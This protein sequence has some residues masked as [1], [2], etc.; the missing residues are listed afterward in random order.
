MS[1]D[2]YGRLNVNL[3]S[4]LENYRGL[5]EII[6]INPTHMSDEEKNKFLKLS[7]ICPNLKVIDDL[8]M[9]S[10]TLEEYEKAEKW[11]EDTIKNINPNW[12]KLQKIAYIDN[13]IGKKVSYSP[14]FETEVFD[15]GESRNI[16]KIINKGYGVCNGIAQL[17][18][19]MLNRIGVT[20]EIVTS[21]VHAFV[22]IKDIQI[23]IEDGNYVVGDT[24]IDPTWNLA[25]HR[26]GGR[27]NDFCVSYERIRSHDIE[28]DGKD[29]KAHKLDEENMETIEL[30]EKGLREVFSSIGIA[31]P[32]GNFPI[33]ELMDMSKLLDEFDFSGEEN[34]EKQLLLLTKYYKGFASCQNSTIRVLASMIDSTKNL[35]F[36]KCII[37]RVFDRS[38]KKKEPVLYVYANFRE[39]TKRFWVADKDLHGF[40]SISEQKFEEKFKCYDED[41]KKEDGISPWKAKNIEKEEDLTRSSGEI[42][43]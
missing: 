35:E 6:T 15:K 41:L 29:S 19:Y 8:K 20:S 26:Y 9:I 22:L 10:V 42:Q 13:V 34:L 39:G 3:D 33:K 31:D 17:E 40:V 38:D 2:S 21:K 5:D 11:I 4:D 36:N 27:P 1:I 28:E 23:Q 24:I 37:N 25:A 7:A 16:W 14:D 12:T 43:I 18:Q 30:S 32:K